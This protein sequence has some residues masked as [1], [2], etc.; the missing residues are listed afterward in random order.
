MGPFAFIPKKSKKS[1]FPGIACVSKLQKERRWTFNSR[2]A[3]STRFPWRAHL[4]G[5]DARGA[6]VSLRALSVSLLSDGVR[7]I[8]GLFAGEALKLQLVDQPRTA[9]VRE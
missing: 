4:H 1:P 6:F 7:A 8:G 5:K 9:H 3:L 2:G